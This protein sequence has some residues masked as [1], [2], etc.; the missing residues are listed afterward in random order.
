MELKTEQKRV[1]LRKRCFKS[2]CMKNVADVFMWDRR[3]RF[4]QIDKNRFEL[5]EIKANK[6]KLRRG[7]A[8]HPRF[9]VGMALMRGK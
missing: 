6:Q 2:R 9:Y 3:I 4:F 8:S 5:G 1:I 7:V